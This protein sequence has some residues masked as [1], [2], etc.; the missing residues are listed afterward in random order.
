MNKVLR[1]S[2]VEKASTLTKSPVKKLSNAQKSKFALYNEE[3]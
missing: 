1:G 2:A 3:K